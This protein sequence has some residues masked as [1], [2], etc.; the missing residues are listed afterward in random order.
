MALRNT[1]GNE[2]IR[3]RWNSHGDNIEFVQIG[4]N[5]ISKFSRVK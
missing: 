2:D 3:S 1:S 5:E 4:M